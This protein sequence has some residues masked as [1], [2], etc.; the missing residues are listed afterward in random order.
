MELGERQSAIKLMSFIPFSCRE[1]SQQWFEYL[2]MV[3]QPVREEAMAIRPSR[4]SGQ[5]FLVAYLT[6]EM[7]MAQPMHCQVYQD[8][9]PFTY[10]EHLVILAQHANEPAILALVERLQEQIG[11]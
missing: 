11:Q 2:R 1:R 3:N 4:H 5:S 10:T 6:E 7:R 9:D 8:F